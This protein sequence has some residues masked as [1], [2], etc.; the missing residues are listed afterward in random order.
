[1]EEIIIATK[2]MGKMKEFT[3]MLSPLGYSVISAKDAGFTE[4]VEETGATFA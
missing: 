3:R 2:N 4:E 1:M